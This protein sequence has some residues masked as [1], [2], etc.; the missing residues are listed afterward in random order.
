MRATKMKRIPDEITAADNTN[1]QEIIPYNKFDYLSKILYSRLF[2]SS[3]KIEESLDD[4][5]K[6]KRISL[7]EWFRIKN[8]HNITNK[9]TI[10]IKGN[11]NV[12]GN[13]VQGD[14]Y[15]IVYYNFDWFVRF[16]DCAGGT[17]N[18]VLQELWS[19]ILANEIQHPQ[20][21]SLR[22]LDIVKNMTAKEANSFEKL[23]KY[24]SRCGKNDHI[25]LEIGFVSN[26]SG[27]DLC[28]EYIENDQLNYE[29]DIVPLQECGLLSRD[30]FLS[31][32]YHD[33]DQNNVLLFSINNVAFLLDFKSEVE[34]RKKQK[35]EDKLLFNEDAYFLTGSG[36]EVF[37]SV[38]NMSNIETSLAYYIASFLYYEKKYKK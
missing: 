2:D 21:C 18:D 34:L 10:K 37:Y 1:E 16:Y 12:V 30:R 27:N 3:D 38:K 19:K 20:S 23:C 9:A 5:L 11:N 36:I 15:N 24:V 17:S 29:E 6:E 28:R 8:L 31:F 35:M 33:D 26:V 22:T 14:Y 4:L 32:D 7:F 25:V 13:I